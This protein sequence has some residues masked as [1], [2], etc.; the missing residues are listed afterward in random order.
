MP[1]QKSGNDDAGGEKSPPFPVGPRKEQKDVAA[2][3]S[4][5]G[6]VG[7]CRASI[8]AGLLRAGCK[9]R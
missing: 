8:V 9:V 5:P 1:W 2:G 3:S 6:H 4:L 7:L